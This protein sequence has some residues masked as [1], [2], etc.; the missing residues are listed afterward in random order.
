MI[1][2]SVLLWSTSVAG[3]KISD[4]SARYKFNI[5]QYDHA[6]DVSEPMKI[7]MRPYSVK[8]KEAVET[9]L[10]RK[11]NQE[12]WH[13]QNQEDLASVVDALKA[14]AIHEEAQQ[15]FER[16]YS[17]CF[18]IAEKLRF[19][20]NF[21]GFKPFE[22]SL[23]L[24]EV[25]SFQNNFNQLDFNNYRFAL[26]EH[27]MFVVTYVEIFN[28]DNGKKYFFHNTDDKSIKA[29]PINLSVQGLEF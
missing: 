26:N 18:F 13:P 24:T 23:P 16:T 6:H 9:E 25:E 3:Q 20:V 8:V 14:E 2:C 5:D 10:T 22:I 19:Q 1:L 7:D 17:E 15:E 21:G 11:L 12:N 27:D 29:P 28:P 4:I